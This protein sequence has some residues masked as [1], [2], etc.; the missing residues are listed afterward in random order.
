[1]EIGLKGDG[2]DSKKS[3]SYKATLAQLTFLQGK[4]Q[5][6]III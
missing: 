6:V 2:L 5:K 3:A 1:M 4:N